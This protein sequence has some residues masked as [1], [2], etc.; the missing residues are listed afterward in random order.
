MNAVLHL[1]AK[2]I[3]SPVGG[4]GGYDPTRE[5]A[6]DDRPRTDNYVRAIEEARMRRGRL[7]S[8]R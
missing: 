6:S 1:L 7:L 4:R 3:G 5:V 8:R 2:A